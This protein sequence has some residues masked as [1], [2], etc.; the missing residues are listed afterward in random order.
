MLIVP[1][2]ICWKITCRVLWKFVHLQSQIYLHLPNPTQS[3]DVEFVDSWWVQ[4]ISRS[5]QMYWNHENFI[6]RTYQGVVFRNCLTD[7]KVVASFSSQSHVNPSNCCLPA[8]SNIEHFFSLELYHPSTYSRVIA[9]WDLNREE[10]ITT[11][12][13][14]STFQS[15]GFPTFD[16]ICQKG[17]P[18]SPKQKSWVD[19]FGSFS[20]INKTSNCRRSAHPK[21]GYSS[22]LTFSSPVLFVNVSW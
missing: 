20:S 5:A 10:N 14:P 3:H 22:S 9:S 2:S 21:T 18:R 17:I 11:L 8:H 19:G 7:V 15:F 6:G 13:L 4:T 1:N 16:P 12:Y